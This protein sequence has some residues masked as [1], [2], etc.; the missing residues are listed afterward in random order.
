MFPGLPSI[1]EKEYL[2]VST[3]TSSRFSTDTEYYSATM[4]N[5]MEQHENLLPQI[6]R[7]EG[8]D[9]TILWELLASHPHNLDEEVIGII[10]MEDVME[11]ILQVILKCYS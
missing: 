4:T 3:D 9:G 10:T 5:F 1:N 7:R 6:G 8:G 11:E 2:C